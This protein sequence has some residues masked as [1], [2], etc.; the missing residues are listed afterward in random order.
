M[1]LVSSSFKLWEGFKQST[2]G[3]RPADTAVVVFVCIELN[4]ALN[5]FS[6]TNAATIKL[7]FLLIMYILCT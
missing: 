1:K 2:F 7:F 4:E 6:L 5:R 3:E